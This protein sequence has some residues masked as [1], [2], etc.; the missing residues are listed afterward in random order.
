MRRRCRYTVTVRCPCIIWCG[1]TCLVVLN[2]ENCCPAKYSCRSAS[3]QFDSELASRLCDKPSSTLLK[4]DISTACP[5]AG[6]SYVSKRSKRRS[7]YFPVSRR[8]CAPRVSV[9]SCA[10]LSYVLARSPLP[11]WQCSKQKTSSLYF[12]NVSL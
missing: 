10:W 4:R 7:A 11:S 8:V 5:V 12:S 6:R 1:A 9:Q 3:T 2:G